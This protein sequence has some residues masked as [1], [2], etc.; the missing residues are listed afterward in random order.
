MGCAEAQ[1]PFAG[2]LRVSLSYEFFPLPVLSLS[3]EKGSGGWSK[4]FFSTLLVTANR[5]T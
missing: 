1:S 2:S 4:G 5:R 3:K